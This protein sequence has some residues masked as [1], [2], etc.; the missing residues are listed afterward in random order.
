MT[1]RRTLGSAIELTPEKLAFIHGETKHVD[2]PST[3]ANKLPKERT[4]D[5]EVTAAST[6]ATQ[7]PSVRISRR[8][9]RAAN[10]APARV[11][12]ELD[13]V[14]V[15]VTIRLPHRLA[16]ALKR[17]YL[18]QKLRREKPDTQQEIVEEA[19]GNWLNRHGFLEP[20]A[21]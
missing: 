6:T 4:I 7:E 1:N 8:S 14:L 3:D 13:R 18:E 20:K 15:P 2:S 9:P 19:L 10:P 16:S 12:E 17:A 21:S 5:L 11:S